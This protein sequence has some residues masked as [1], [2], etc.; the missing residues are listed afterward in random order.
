M[1]LRGYCDRWD[2]VCSCAK[3]CL[4]RMLS[5]Y[6][7]DTL[8]VHA[9]VQHRPSNLS[10]VL[11]LQEERFTLAILEAEDLRVTTDVELSLYVHRLSA[12]CCP[13]AI[14]SPCPDGLLHPQSFTPPSRSRARGVDSHLARVDLLAAESVLVDTHVGGIVE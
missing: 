8:L 3:D 11:A 10:R 12:L 6:L 13:I 7:G 14:F 9:S 1:L 2:S 5:S 4:S